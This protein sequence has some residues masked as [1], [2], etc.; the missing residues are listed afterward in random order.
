MTPKKVVRFIDE[1]YSTAIM[2]SHDSFRTGTPHPARRICW[3]PLFSATPTGDSPTGPPKPKR[4]LSPAVKRYGYCGSDGATGNQ[5]VSR[6]WMDGVEDYTV[7]HVD[8]E[9]C[10][11]MRMTE[12]R[13]PT[14][15][16]VQQSRFSSPSKPE[17]RVSIRRFSDIDRPPF[18]EDDEGVQLPRHCPTMGRKQLKTV[19]RQMDEEALERQTQK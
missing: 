15:I 8:E 17:R 7:Q 19:R 1:V 10:R 4:K 11:G 2:S 14:S 16:I 5:R 12:G 9:R 3:D 18:D 6:N 13:S